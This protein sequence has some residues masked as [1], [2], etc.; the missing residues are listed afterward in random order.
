MPPATFWG[1]FGM[2]WTIGGEPRRY[3]GGYHS[4]MVI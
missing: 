2:F 4:D 1:P 3:A